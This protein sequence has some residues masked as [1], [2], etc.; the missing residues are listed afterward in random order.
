MSGTCMD[1]FITGWYFALAGPL[2]CFLVRHSVQFQA[3]T[4]VGATAKSAGRQAWA[5]R[6]LQFKASILGFLM[7][8]ALADNLRHRSF[9]HHGLFCTK[10][11]EDKGKKIKD[12]RGQVAPALTVGWND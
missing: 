7:K 9:V 4:K 11:V 8:E 1:L 10:V 6:C 12:R 3:D 5:V 2:L